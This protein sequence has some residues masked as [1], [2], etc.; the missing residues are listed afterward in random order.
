MFQQCCACFK[1]ENPVVPQLNLYNVCHHN[2]AARAT[3]IH[4][5]QC[6]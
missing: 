2:Y 1:F 4:V 5:E 6:G 3:N